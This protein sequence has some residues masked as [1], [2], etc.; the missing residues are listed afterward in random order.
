MVPQLIHFVI[1]IVVLGAPTV[2]LTHTKQE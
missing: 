2:H 1:K